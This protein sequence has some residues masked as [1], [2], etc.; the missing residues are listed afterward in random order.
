[1]AVVAF[2]SVLLA[3][4]S[5]SEPSDPKADV[6][7]TGTVIVTGSH[8]DT[9]LVIAVTNSEAYELIGDHAADL[10]GLQQRRVTVRG[11]V[12]REARGPGLPAQLEVDSYSVLR[13]DRR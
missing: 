13:P 8:R 3:C 10:W 12:V 5:P 6:E 1:M 9:R 7:V 11:R 4:A 2:A